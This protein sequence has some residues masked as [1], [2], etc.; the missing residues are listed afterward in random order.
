MGNC[1]I[2][3]AGEISKILIDKNDDDLLIAADG[4]YKTA[5]DNG[6]IPDIALGDFDSLGYVPKFHNV[7][8]PP[9]KKDD[10]DTFFAAKEGV[11]RG[12][13]DYSLIGVIGGFI[14]ELF[15]FLRWI[16][17]CERGKNKILGIVFDFLFFVCLFF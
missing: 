17:G 1:Y 3:S 6:L 2:I 7:V 9:Q 11:K 16:C 4:G 8:L 12:F 13:D 5:I 14:Y 15:A 10:T